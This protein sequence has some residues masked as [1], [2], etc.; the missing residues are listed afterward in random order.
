MSGKKNKSSKAS[1]PV[2][3]ATTNTK[4]SAPYK[5]GIVKSG[6]AGSKK[7]LTNTDDQPVQRSIFG[8][9]TG[10]TPVSL[11]HEHC[12]KANWEKPEYDIKRRKDGQFLGTITLSQRNK[13]TAQMQ[14]V[15]MTPPEECQLPTAI[16][17]RHLAATYVLHR[18]KSHMP[19]Y[20]VLPPQHRDYWRQFDAAKTNA[21]AWQYEP[22]PFTAHAPLNTP[23]KHRQIPTKEH[24]ASAVPMPVKASSNEKPTEMD[25][26]MRKDWKNLPAIQMGA[27]NRELVERVIKKSRIAYQ[28]VSCSRNRHKKTM[29]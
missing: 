28:P 21:N 5:K 13:K 1:T 17:A 14:T 16:E 6:N 8:D 26:K 4:K 3:A 18:V 9:W 25:E 22:D 12:Q 23:K 7:D 20:R 11:L 10:K 24:A 2:P 15:T 19:L 29:S 27:E